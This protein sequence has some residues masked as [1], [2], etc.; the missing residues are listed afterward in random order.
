MSPVRP[1]IR[2]R[3]RSAIVDADIARIAVTELPG[4]PL[5]RRGHGPRAILATV[6]SL[7]RPS[8]P[9][10]VIVMPRG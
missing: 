4:T 1:T 8:E 6:R 7:G 3:P 10:R 9:D 5:T 2:I